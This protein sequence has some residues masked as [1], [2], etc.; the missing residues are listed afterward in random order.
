MKVTNIAAVREALL[1]R[2]LEPG[3]PA[4]VPAEVVAIDRKAYRRIRCP[5][6]NKRM[7]FAPCH[8]GQTY[9]GLSVCRSCGEV[10]EV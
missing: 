4:R 8:K 7:T 9:I 5:R 6:C 3:A 10:E 2:G 1:E